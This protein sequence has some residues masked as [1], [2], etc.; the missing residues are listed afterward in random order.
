MYKLMIVDDEKVMCELLPVIIDWNELDVEV[1]GVCKNGLEAYEKALELQ[2]DIVLTDIKMPG[3]S[4]LELIKKLH[5]GGCTARFILLSAYGEFEYAREAMKYNV[6]HYLL[7]PCNEEQI[8]QA[9]K[10][11]CSELVHNHASEQRSEPEQ[12]YSEITQK[13]LHIVEEELDNTNLS[14]KWIAENKL[15]MN[16]DYISRKFS[17]DTGQKF[18]SYLNAYRMSKARELLLERK[19]T[20]INMLAEKV[21]YGNNPQY[22]SQIFKKMTNLSPKEY[23]KSCEKSD[24]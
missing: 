4:G 2:P 5:E 15:Y 9:V 19:V 23:M 1:V 6:K 21:G 16:V 24:F 12:A 18:S 22:F 14:L 17:A 10:E 7:K 20:N 3:L 13:I 8:M 11:I